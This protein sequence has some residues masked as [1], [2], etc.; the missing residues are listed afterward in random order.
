MMSSGNR[1][2]STRTTSHGNFAFNTRDRVEVAVHTTYEHDLASP[3]GQNVSFVIT[4]GQ[5]CDK[6]RELRLPG[7]VGSNMETGSSM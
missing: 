4:E 7:D 5:P 3:K 1:R 2:R 6:L